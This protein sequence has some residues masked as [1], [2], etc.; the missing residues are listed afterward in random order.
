MNTSP[1]PLWT[2]LQNKDNIL[3]KYEINK[4][5]D[6]Y[7]EN[8]KCRWEILINYLKKMKDF[9]WKQFKGQTLISICLSKLQKLY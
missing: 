3:P 5:D 2:V 4:C 6:V 1:A 7:W 8:W 9:I